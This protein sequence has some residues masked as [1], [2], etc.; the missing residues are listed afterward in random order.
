[1]NGSEH[2]LSKLLDNLP[3]M[4]YRCRHDV[5]WT[6]EGNGK[7]ADLLRRV[8]EDWRRAGRPAASPA[9]GSRRTPPRGRETASA[10]TGTY[11]PAAAEPR[12]RAP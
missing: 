4:V 3:G 10:G 7:V 12:G 6:P 2:R 1:M 8:H 9:T 11:G 5:H